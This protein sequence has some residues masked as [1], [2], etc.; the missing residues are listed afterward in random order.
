M[1]GAL[2][3]TE[4]IVEVDRESINHLKIKADQ[5]PDRRYRLCLHRSSEDTLHQ[6]AMAFCKDAYIRP[7]RHPKGK[8]E[9]Y[10]IIEGEMTVYFFDEEQKVIRKIEMGERTSGKTFFYRLDTTTWHMPVPQSQFVVFLETNLG[11]YR[12]NVD[13]EFADWSPMDTDKTA[14]SAFLEKTRNSI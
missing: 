10:Q 6:S 5:A 8:T 2:F 7:H 14:V 12:K 9:S 11:P 3:S 1:S 4:D 13:V